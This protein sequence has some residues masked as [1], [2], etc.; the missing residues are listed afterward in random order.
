MDFVARTVASLELLLGKAQH[1]LPM[2][3]DSWDSAP[4]QLALNTTPFAQHPGVSPARQYR[5]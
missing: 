4:H 1:G 5:S 2:G 3:L